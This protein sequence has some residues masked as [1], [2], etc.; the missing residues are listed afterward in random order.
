MNDVTNPDTE[1][2]DAETVEDDFEAFEQQADADEAEEITE[3]DDDDNPDESPETDE[4]KDDE[5]DGLEDIEIDGKTYKVPKDAALRQADYTRKTQEL[6][7]KRNV[8]DATFERLQTV[9]QAETQALA[10][11][12]IVAAQLKQYEDVDWDAWEE[13][14]AQL[15]TREAQKHWRIF[16]GL[17][18]QRDEAI[19][20]YNNVGEAKRSLVQQ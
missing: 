1:V 11:V 7:E 6:A 13:Q 12:A 4:V 19:A 15:G 18:K 17:E 16:Q 20:Q 14:D 5:P 2:T 3:A 9:S 10:S 8:V